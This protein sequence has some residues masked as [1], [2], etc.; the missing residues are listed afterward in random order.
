M[1]FQ[2]DVVGAD[3]LAATL[4]AA[5]HKIGDLSK[6]LT[7]GAKRIWLRARSNAPRRTG[8]LAG[9]IHAQQSRSEALVGSGLIYAPVIHNGWPA[10]HIRANPFLADAFGQEQQAVVAGFADRVVNAIGT[11]KGA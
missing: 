8:R 7:E 6:P 9:S 2:V 4:A 3:R 5:A 1:T 11:V 10:H